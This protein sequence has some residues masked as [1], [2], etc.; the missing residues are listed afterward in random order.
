MLDAKALVVCIT[1]PSNI[2]KNIFYTPTLGLGLWFGTGDAL[3]NAPK[4]NFDIQPVTFELFRPRSRFAWGIAFRAEFFR[5]DRENLDDLIFTFFLKHEFFFKENLSIEAQ[6]YSDIM[7][8][9]Y[10]LNTG[11][12]DRDDNDLFTTVG[13]NYF[14]MN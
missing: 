7:G 12:S 2:A 6:L 4:I 11:E 1:N 8:S 14:L 10:L 9:N 13:F 5:E 3:E